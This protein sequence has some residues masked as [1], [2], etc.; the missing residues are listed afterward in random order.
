M[1]ALKINKNIRICIVAHNAYGALTGEDTGHIGGIE[2]Q[3]S[4]MAVWER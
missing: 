2:R 1:G 3:T 4:L